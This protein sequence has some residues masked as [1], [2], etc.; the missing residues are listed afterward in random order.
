MY[1]HLNYL[2]LPDSL[3]DGV[4][5]QVHTHHV[6]GGV[7]QVKVTRV[8]PHYERHRSQ[9]DISHLQWTQRDIGTQPAQGEAH[10]VIQRTP[11][12]VCLCAHQ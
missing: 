6:S 10:L 2:T 12:S 9:K 8:D 3:E 5:V 7:V 11:V 1:T 4:G